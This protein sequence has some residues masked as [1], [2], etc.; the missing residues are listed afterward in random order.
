MGE[1]IKGRWP[2]KINPT[3]LFSINGADILD[4][5]HKEEPS[6]VDFSFIIKKEALASFLQISPDHLPSVSELLTSSQGIEILI[7]KGWIKREGLVQCFDMNLTR[8]IVR[9]PDDMS[10]CRFDLSFAL[11]NSNVSAEE[12]QLLEEGYTVESRYTSSE[13]DF[14]R[15]KKETDSLKAMGIPYKT[16]YTYDGRPDW[17]A[18]WVKR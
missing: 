3:A 8:Q 16:I 14:I 1:V 7:K 6:K 18:L 5:E 10:I 17:I 12:R 11:K 2:E 4:Y 13:V 15:A 9:H